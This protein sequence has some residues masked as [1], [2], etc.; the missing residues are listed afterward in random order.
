MFKKLV[1]CIVVTL[2]TVSSVFAGIQQYQRAAIL[3]KGGGATNFL[4]DASALLGYYMNSSGT[5]VDRTGNGH[6][7]T[8]TGSV[9]LSTTVPTGYAGNSR[10]FEDGTS[11]NLKSSTASLGGTGASFTVCAW[12][13]FESLGADKTI[14]SQYESTGNERGWELYSDDSSGDNLVLQVTP[15]GTNNPTLAIG[16]T[17]FSTATYYHVCGVHDATANELRV[18]VDGDL[19]A[20]ATAYS[21]DV[22][23]SAEDFTVGAANS[24]VASD[25]DGLIDEFIAFTRVLS[26]AEIE[27]LMATGTD[28]TKGGND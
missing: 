1:I 6:D 26:E 27:E 24:A 21:S 12:A 5:E 23:A 22:H 17:V 28:G 11:E 16:D 2:I 8:E 19:D 13:Q 3:K 14:G 20:T 9:N 10:D 18:Y 15:D 7:G 4:D 25:M